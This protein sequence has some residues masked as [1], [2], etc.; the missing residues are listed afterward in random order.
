MYELAKKYQIIAI[1][2]LPQIAAMA[3]HHFRIKKESDGT[4]TISG[5]ETLD[6]NESV[7]EIAKLVGGE[8]ISPAALE[9]ARDLKGKADFFKHK[10]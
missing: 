5:I 1:T 8:G 2:H 3:D 9:N 6:Y 4:N 10:I 7:K